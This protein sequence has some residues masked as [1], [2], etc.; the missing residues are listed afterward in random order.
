MKLIK[1][2]QEGGTEVVEAKAGKGS[3]T[4]STAYAT[5]RLVFALLRAMSGESNIVGKEYCPTN[6][7][8][9]PS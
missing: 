7:L 6:L 8:Q 2:I 1:R 4:L 3:A 5:S 9:R